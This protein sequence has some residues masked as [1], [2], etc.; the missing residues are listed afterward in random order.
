MGAI[1]LR[2]ALEAKEVAPADFRSRL[3]GAYRHAGPD[4]YCCIT[5]ESHQAIVAGAFAEATSVAG[6]SR[7]CHQVQWYSPCS[8]TVSRQRSDEVLLL[9]FIC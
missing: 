7:H 8:I 3:C 9:S 2:C 4:P 5:V 6:R 1:G